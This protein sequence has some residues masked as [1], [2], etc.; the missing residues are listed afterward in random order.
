MRLG[1]IE[2]IC[3]CFSSQHLSDMHWL[4]PFDKPLSLALCSLCAFQAVSYRFF[5]PWIRHCE[6]I[7]PS[8]IRALG[9]QHYRELLPSFWN[10]YSGSWRNILS[11]LQYRKIRD[12]PRTFMLSR[13]LVVCNQFVAIVGT[14]ATRLNGAPMQKYH[15]SSPIDIGASKREQMFV[16]GRGS[17]IPSRFPPLRRRLWLAGWTDLTAV[18]LI[19][20]AGQRRAG[21]WR[22]RSLKRDVGAH[23]SGGWR[24]AFTPLRIG[25]KVPTVGSGCTGHAGLK[26]YDFSWK[27]RSVG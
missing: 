15:A 3:I 24:F 9:F 14:I 18:H 11:F 2:S 4:N 13:I 10:T 17:W 7:S 8:R 21:S 22:Q 16:L 26:H 1:N 25:Q 12:T 6:N 5:S 23:T 19:L 27:L 20:R